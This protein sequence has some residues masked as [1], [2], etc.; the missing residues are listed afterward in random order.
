M[1]STYNITYQTQYS[2]LAITTI[3]NIPKWREVALSSL[4]RFNCLGADS[5][6]GQ[7][8]KLL[9]KPETASAT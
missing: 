1:G 7:L 2:S 5:L 4:F 8:M 6:S 3:K 9:A